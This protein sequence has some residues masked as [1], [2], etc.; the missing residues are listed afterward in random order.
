MGV[1]YQVY[2]LMKNKQ[3]D[4]E[5]YLKHERFVNPK[6]INFEYEA[7]T[8]DLF[9]KLISFASKTIDN[10]QPN[11][12]EGGYI[13]SERDMK[14]FIDAVNENMF[15]NKVQYYQLMAELHDF[16]ISK[17]QEKYLIVTFCD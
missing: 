13:L 14:K 1:Y 6:H 5:W 16:R 2:G 17:H 9:E 15:T 8:G 4:L 11:L 3:K 10:K 7:H 12:G